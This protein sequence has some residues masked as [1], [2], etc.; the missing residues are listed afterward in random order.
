MQDS[1]LKLALMYLEGLP[2]LPPG[3]AQYHGL[4]KGWQRYKNYSKV[5]KKYIY[6]E[7]EI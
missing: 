6:G 4:A 7:K 1:K 2:V 5:L 3:M